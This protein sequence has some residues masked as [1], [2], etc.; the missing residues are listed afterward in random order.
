MVYVL[1]MLLNTNADH[2]SHKNTFFYLKTR[3]LVI[4]KN[5]LRI[6]YE[7]NHVLT[8]DL[9]AI[10]STV[11]LTFHIV[12]IFNSQNVSRSFLASRIEDP[13]SNFMAGAWQGYAIICHKQPI[14]VVASSG[15]LFKQY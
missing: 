2:S 9:L 13:T 12:Y 4:A 11:V 6:R 5:S 7:V 14:R 3:F 15:Y 1:L 8:I 10:L